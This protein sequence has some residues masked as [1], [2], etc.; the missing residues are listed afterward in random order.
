MLIYSNLKTYLLSNRPFPNYAMQLL[1]I[2]AI[3]MLLKQAD[4]STAYQN[5]S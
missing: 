5:Y 3:A 4:N 1:K 2:Q